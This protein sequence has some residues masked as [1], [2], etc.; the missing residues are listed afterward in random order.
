VTALTPVGSGRDIVHGTFTHPSPIAA[1]V[2]RGDAGRGAITR[3]AEELDGQA[4]FGQ[5]LHRLDAARFAAQAERLGV[6]AVIALEDD[7]PQLAWLP[8]STAFRRRI[9]LAPFVIFAR[10]SAVSVP[11]AGD[12]DSWRVTLAG[13]AGAW[14]A[15]RVAYYPLWRAEAAGERLP[16]R[17]GADGILEVRLSRPQQA[18]TLRYGAGVPEI[19]G[20]A[21][22][23]GAVV[24]LA[25]VAWRAASA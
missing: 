12:G 6:V 25:V 1:L 5:P 20:L 9:T 16:K 14:A 7:A 19:L 13:E 3:L 2:Y 21:V 17:R 22:S 18:V 15:A 11:A 24:A 8:E 23:A 4:L 10:E